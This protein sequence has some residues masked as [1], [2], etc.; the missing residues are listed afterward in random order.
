MKAS[1]V[2]R[3]ARDLV[4][5][6]WVTGWHAADADGRQAPVARDRAVNPAAVRFSVYGAVSR[7]LLTE[8]MDGALDS[9][10]LWEALTNEA[11]KLRTDR[12]NPHIHPVISI[13]DRPGQTLDGIM[14][15]LGNVIE[16]LEA[17]E[18]KA[19][20]PSQVLP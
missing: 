9:T 1:E 5:K 10:A 6:G 16:R 11:V 8:R 18:G 2:V 19:A 17:A 7:V 20:E 15:Y 12:D 13:N 14:E 4:Q 3:A